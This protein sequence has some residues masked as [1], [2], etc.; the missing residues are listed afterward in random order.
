MRNP[1]DQADDL[2]SSH[3]TSQK[4]KF[5]TVQK[6]P[7][8]TA[9]DKTSRQSTIA[10][11]VTKPHI[12]LMKGEP[13]AS[14]KRQRLGDVAEGGLNNDNISMNAYTTT[15]QVIDLTG[16]GRTVK[17]PRPPPHS[18]AKKLVV[19]NMR[20]TSRTDLDEYYGRTWTQLNLALT[21]VFGGQEP[22]QSLEQLYRGVEDVCRH[23]KAE[24]LYKELRRRCQSFLDEEMLPSIIAQSGRGNVGVLRTV[25]A[26]WMSWSRQMVRLVF[27]FIV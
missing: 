27:K 23:G 17:P 12:S 14:I 21:A 18:G 26:A 13:R 4:R 6:V 5:P 11:I 25:H 16:D 2:R 9:T 19:K 20:R 3:S 22:I 8:T 7:N 15:S 1:G 10:D 24:S